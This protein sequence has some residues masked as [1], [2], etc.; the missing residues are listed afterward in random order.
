MISEHEANHRLEYAKKGIY[1]YGAK[2]WSEIPDNIREQE[3]F[4]RFKKHL[5]EYLMNLK[6]Q[7]RPFG[8]A[9]SLVICSF[10]FF[11]LL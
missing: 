10:V 5:R 9:A 3:S 8:R 6:P 7:I 4:A 1:F 2:N 11:V